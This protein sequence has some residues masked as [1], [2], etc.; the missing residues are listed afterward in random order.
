MQTKVKDYFH[1]HVKANKSKNINAFRIEHGRCLMATV[2]NSQ[3][4]LSARGPIVLSSALGTNLFPFA[5][6][7]GLKAT[8]KV[9]R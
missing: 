7:R 3:C 8:A 2:R 6:H 1:F 4:K 9:R 5:K